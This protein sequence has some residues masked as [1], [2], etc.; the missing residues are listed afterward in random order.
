MAAFDTKLDQY[1][2]LAVEVGVNVQPGQTLVVTAPLVA[3]EYVRKVVKRAYAVGA[4]Y[5]HV[6]WHDEETTRLRFAH[7]PADSFSEYPIPWRAKGW[8]QMASENAAFLSISAANPDLLSG[9]DPVRIQQ[10]NKAQGLAMQPFRKFTMSDKVSWSIVACPSEAWADKV[11]PDLPQ[12]ERV[13]ALW[14]AIFQA[15]RIDQDDPV[16]AWRDHTSILD[17]KADRLNSRK[18]RALHYTAPGTDL[19]IELPDDHIWVSAGSYSEQGHLFIAN[20]PTEEVFTAPKRDGVNGTVVSTKP[21]SYGGNLI[22]NIRITFRDGRI[23]DFAADAGYDTLRGLIETDEG[24]RMLGEV[25]L[26]PHE[27]PISKTNLVFYNTLFDENASNHLAIGKGYA[28][29]LAGG[30]SMSAEELE[31]S[32]LNDSLVHVDFMIGSAEME[33]DGILPDGTR[34]P[35]FRQGN[36][37]F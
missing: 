31:R 24:S 4:K 23:V 33:I 1:A 34:E 14:E 27:S 2:R 29:C 16:A 17:S 8:E 9:I 18:Y 19:T 35:V 5:V 13:D 15:T 21:L 36:W 25:A 26:V 28:F 11:F 3:A 30:K 12:E 22:E 6:D 7:A 10:A 37:A 32:G 20:M